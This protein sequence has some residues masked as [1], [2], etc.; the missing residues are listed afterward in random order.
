MNGLPTVNIQV[1]EP[2][3]IEMES[4]LF[5]DSMQIYPALHISGPILDSLMTP[6]RIGV[7]LMV[8]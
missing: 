1:N 2:L 7:N 4:E 3:Y 5:D 8:T 6:F